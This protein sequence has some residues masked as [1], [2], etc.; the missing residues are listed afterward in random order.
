MKKKKKSKS[1]ESIKVIGL[2]E[3]MSMKLHFK[4][5]HAVV[6]YHEKLHIFF[7]SNANDVF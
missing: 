5:P 2:C 3:F 6:E 1:F 4:K 7:R